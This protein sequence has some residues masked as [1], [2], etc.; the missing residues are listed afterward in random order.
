MAVFN[1]STFDASNLPWQLSWFLRGWATEQVLASYEREQKP[2]ATHGSGE[3][4]QAAALSMAKRADGAGAMSDNNWSNAYMRSLLGVKLDVAGTGAW[5]LVTRSTRPVVTPGDRL[6][7][8]LL[9]TPQG[10]EARV[11]DLYAVKFTAL[12]FA[13]AR[14]RPLVPL[15]SSLALQ[16]F[17]V[18]RYYAPLDFGERERS[19]L[20]PGSALF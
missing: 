3:M 12:N 8:Y 13:D 6:P 4:A 15:K 1:T 20:D 2:L 18:S 16:H 19:M 10:H 9:N 5:S 7:D 14:R 11:H 17:L